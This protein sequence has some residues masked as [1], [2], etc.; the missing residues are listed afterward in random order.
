MTEIEEVGPKLKNGLTDRRREVKIS[1]ILAGIAGGYLLLCFVAPATLS[2]DTVP[3]LSGRANAIDY[4][5]QNS[6]GNRDHGEGSSLVHDQS[7]HGGIFAW[8]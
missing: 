2:S 7:L 6:W 4:A 1:K 5:D 3:E 8:T